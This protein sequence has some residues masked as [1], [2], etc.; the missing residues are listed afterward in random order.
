M[1]PH[2]EV[3]ARRTVHAIAQAANDCRQRIDEAL[4][5]RDADDFSRDAEAEFDRDRRDFVEPR[6]HGARQFFDR[7][8]HRGSD[9]GDELPFGLALRFASPE[10]E[11]RRDLRGVRR[12]GR[13]PSRMQTQADDR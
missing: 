8:L 11:Q 12:T 13:R 6:L 10:V 9:V 1:Q 7:L 3:G 5:D 4:V 2:D